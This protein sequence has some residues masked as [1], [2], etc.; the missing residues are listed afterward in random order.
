MVCMIHFLYKSLRDRRVQKLEKPRPGSWVFSYNLSAEDIDKLIELGFDKDILEDSLDYFEVPRFEEHNGVNYFFTRY[1]VHRKDGQ[2]STAPLLIAISDSH[3]LTISHEK[4][5]FLDD[6]AHGRKDIITTQKIKSFLIFI[7]SVVKNY[8]K[9]L[10]KIRREVLRFYGNIEEVGEEDIKR[11]VALESRLSDYLSA[12]IPTND[13]FSLMLRKGK[14]LNLHEED[15]EILEDLQQDTQQVISTAKN[16]SKTVQNIRSAH[17]DILAHKLNITMKT[18]TA[19]TII[20]TVPTIIS[21]IFGMNTWL[22]FSHGVRGFLIVMLIIVVL[23][24]ML[25][26]HFSRKNW[27]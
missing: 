18:L 9:S 3:I 14:I 23:S 8:E 20:F 10:I 1:I 2:I 13:A 7:D 6:F 22:P 11:T 24:W 21:G 5:E 4:P 16:V 15:I 27:I 12:L 17:S 25:Y 19:V 26:I